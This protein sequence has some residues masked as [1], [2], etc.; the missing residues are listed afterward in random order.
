MPEC[1]STNTLASELSDKTNLP[2]G[3]VI[4]TPNQTAGRGQRGNSWQATE[5]LN[6]TFSILLKP[7]FL[8]VKDQFHLTLV[9]SLAVF[10]YLTSLSLNG[11]KI[12]W[13][14][15]MLI[16]V[17]KV[18]GILIENTL[19]GTSIQ[20][21]IVGIGLNINQQ[22][23]PIA[24]ATSVSLQAGRAFDLNDAL[25]SLLS[26]FE[27]RY[28]QLRAGK[29]AALKEE[30]LTNLFGIHETRVF[31]ANQVRFEGTIQGV[32]DNGELVVLTNG[33]HKTFSLKEIS[34]D[35]TS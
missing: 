32:N 21:S 31:I 18:G 30:Y 16:G 11:I 13:P 23:F 20:K 6:L 26:Y 24:S 33:M 7:T 1:H 2:E 34:L 9:T 4:I 12:K 29:S 28:L 10:D 27:Q 25:N 35:L 17:K 19:Q 15:D 14:N 5:G 8:P 3:T 22:E